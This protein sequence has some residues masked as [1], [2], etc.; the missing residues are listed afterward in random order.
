[1]SNY[2]H[3]M[4]TSGMKEEQNNV[5]NVSGIDANIF[6]TILNYLYTGKSHLTIFNAQDLIAAAVYLQIETLISLCEEFLLSNTGTSNCVDVW[7]L[8]VTYNCELLKQKTWIYIVEHFK[9]IEKPQLLS[10]L[11]ECEVLN[12]LHEDNLN[13][14]DEKDIL[15]FVLEWITANN[16]EVDSLKRLIKNVRLPLIDQTS[17]TKISH[18]YEKFRPIIKTALEEQSNKEDSNLNNPRKEKAFVVL[19]RTSYM[20]GISVACYSLSKKKW[21]TLSSNKACSG[22][23]GYSTCSRNEE[24]YLSGA[25]KMYKFSLTENLWTS[26]KDMINGRQCHASG[27][28][29]NSVYVLGGS[30]SM[31]NTTMH[32]FSVVPSIERYNIT[33]DVW[34]VVGEMENPTY[35]SAY[36]TVKTKIF[37]FG[38]AIGC[39]P[40]VYVKDIQCFDTV[41]NTCT[42]IYYN[43]P[44]TLSL[45]TACTSN[46]DIYITCPSGQIIHFNE[47]S[48]PTLISNTKGSQLMGF[49]TVFHDNSLYIMG[50]YS[51]IG[52]T[53]FIHKFDLNTRKQIRMSN[54]KLPFTKNTN[55]Y[56]ACAMHVSRTLL[57]NNTIV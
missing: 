55:E 40:G 18:K 36:A 56:S 12:L 26:L 49:A 13:S 42:K 51:V 25:K 30:S 28:V 19:Q 41:S 50:G 39:I 46:N 5:I 17:L 38:G 2:F 21:Y 54:L 6:S 11:E 4:F 9:S 44:F 29:D 31:L 1:M 52:E 57:S 32:D 53:D 15:E 7:K 37:I 34:E 24:I 27:I 3:A 23:T 33:E 48:S 14:E 10:R 43:L 22:G 35:D 47:E 45:A 16:C 8:G 20:L